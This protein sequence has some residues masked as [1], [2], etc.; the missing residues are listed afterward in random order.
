M[1]IEIMQTILQKIKEYQLRKLEKMQET[2]KK[3]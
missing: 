1:N 3:R 2:Q